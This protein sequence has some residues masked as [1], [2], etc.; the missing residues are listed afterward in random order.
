MSIEE[1]AQLFG[2]KKGTVQENIERFHL[3]MKNKAEHSL[4]CLA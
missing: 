3:K 2:I 1:I 4:I